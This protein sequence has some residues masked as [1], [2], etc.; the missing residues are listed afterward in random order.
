L[1]KKEQDAD[2]L[3]IYDSNGVRYPKKWEALGPRYKQQER[4]ADKCAALE[5]RTQSARPS[6]ITS[7]WRTVN[8]AA[9]LG[10][11]VKK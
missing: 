9:P 10:R 1:L 3:S 8:A 6:G 2:A 7:A 11:P 4:G 5:L